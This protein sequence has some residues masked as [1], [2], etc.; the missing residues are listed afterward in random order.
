MLILRLAGYDIRFQLV[1]S[2]A[3]GAGVSFQKI[4]EKDLVYSVGGGNGFD[5]QRM[6][7]ER[8]GEDNRWLPAVQR[9]SS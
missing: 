5:R 2:R 8:I 4:I 6:V 1:R 3:E 7:E 9:N